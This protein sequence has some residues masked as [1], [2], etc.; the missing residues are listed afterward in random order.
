MKEANLKRLSTV[1]FQLYDILERQNYEDT[2]RSKPIGEEEI[3]R[4]STE[5]FKGSETALYDIIMVS[6]C[7]YTFVKTNRMYNSK[8][9]P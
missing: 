4:W 7:H 9:E 8:R 3:E 6:T 2:K 5:D 1:W